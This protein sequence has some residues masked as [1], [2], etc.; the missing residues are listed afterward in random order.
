MSLLLLLAA[1][2]QLDGFFFNPTV[3][4]AYTLGGDVIPTSC[5]ELV[6]FDGTGGSLYGAWAH[7]PV[8]VATECVDAAADPDVPVVVYFHGNSENID[9][10]WDQIEFYW[11]SGYEVFIFDYRGYGRS[12]GEPSFDGVIADGRLAID[13]V[14]ATTGLASTELIYVGLSLGG[15]VSVHNLVDTPPGILITQ[16]MF[17]NTQK[18]LDDGTQLDMPSGWFFEQ[19]YDNTIPL[20]S[21][22][23]EI[24]YL[25]T[26]G[27]S[28]TYIQPEHAQLVFD[29]AG[30]TTKRLF[31]VPGVDHADAIVEAPEILRP[32]IDCWIRQDCVEQ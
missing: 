30:A 13:Y 7:S 23:T 19:N 17:A 15:F 5:Q 6:S 29:A 16:D 26:H 22:P 18:M 1:C 8:D 21:M 28:D 2:Y 27:D 31:L 14:S 12:W 3:V 24:P 4:E 20:R 11:Q 10:Y 9:G 25:V 32:E